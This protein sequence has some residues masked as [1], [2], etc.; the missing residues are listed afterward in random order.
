MS[1]RT[2]AAAVA[3]LSVACAMTPMACGEGDSSPFGPE[4]TRSLTR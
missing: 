3:A 1:A 2:R 4:A